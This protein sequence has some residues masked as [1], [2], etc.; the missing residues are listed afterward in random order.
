MIEN[1]DTSI[2]FNPLENNTI[3]LPWNLPDLRFDYKVCEN[4]LKIYFN[5]FKICFIFFFLARA[6]INKFDLLLYEF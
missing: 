6:G 5:Q 3:N 4:N 2:C 1:N